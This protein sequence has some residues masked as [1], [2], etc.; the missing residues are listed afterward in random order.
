[1]NRRIL[2]IRARVKVECPSTPISSGGIVSVGFGSMRVIDIMIEFF[3]F[4]VQG[5]EEVVT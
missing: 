5:M 3:H 4:E 2:H 1:M